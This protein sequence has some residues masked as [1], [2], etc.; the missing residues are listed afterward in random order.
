MRSPSTESR[1]KCVNE[2][3]PKTTYKPAEDPLD[4]GEKI[5]SSYCKM[6]CQNG[7]NNR[8]DL[9]F[10]MWRLAVVGVP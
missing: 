4:S 7:N 10:G 8:I 1:D 3:K 5:C 6:F 9:T 2:Y